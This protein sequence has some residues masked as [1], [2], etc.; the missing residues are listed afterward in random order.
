MRDGDMTENMDRN[1]QE[2]WVRVEAECAEQADF[3]D[4]IQTHLVFAMEL[5]I[6]TDPQSLN[7][8]H[9]SPPTKTLTVCQN[10]FPH[11]SYN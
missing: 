4:G 3:S 6:K 11:F 8:L 7:A 1:R 10:S 2:M 5:L 9:S